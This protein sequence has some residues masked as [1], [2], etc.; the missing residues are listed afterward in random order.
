[1]KSAVAT[2]CTA[3]GTQS[4]TDRERTISNMDIFYAI[5]PLYYLSKFVGLISFSL[6]FNSR[7]GEHKFR[8]TGAHNFVQNVYSLVIFCGV[9]AGFVMCVQHVK[10]KLSTNPGQVVSEIFSAPANFISSMTCMVMMTVINRKDMMK[11]VT[12][13]RNIDDKLLEGKGSKIYLKTRRLM[14]IELIVIFSVLIPFLCYDSYFISQFSSYA[15]EVMSRFSIAVNIT[16]VLQFQWTM[17][18]FRHRLGLLNQKI[19]DG[20]CVELDSLRNP[21]YVSRSERY[22]MFGQKHSTGLEERL[23]SNKICSEFREGNTRKISVS[24]IS[25]NKHKDLHNFQQKTTLS[26]TVPCILKLRITYNQIYEATLVANKVFG[27]SIIF[28]LMYCFVST[29]SHTYFTFVESFT[30]FD[31]LEKKMPSLEY[32]IANHV[33]W[34]IIS[35]GKTV[36]VSGSCHMVRE[37]SKILVNNLQKLQLRH[38]IRS[39]VL[40]H[41]QQFS[42]QVSQNAIHFTAFGFFSVNLSLLYTFIASSATYVI[43]LIQFRLK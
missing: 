36:A 43:I 16:T 24:T 11:L 8:S 30:N 7:T 28:T 38:P 22:K 42:S 23:R 3:K 15:F 40:I 18:F 12:K 35:V 17:R 14:L 19:L 20:F 41:L 32:N 26:D 27:I 21:S 9:T 25:D 31:E 33:I 5:K 6:H 34:V 10:T 2:F 39:D 29:V 4:H 13:L 37:E 1:M